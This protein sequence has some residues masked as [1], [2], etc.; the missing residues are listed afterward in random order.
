MTKE[1]AFKI[2]DSL[3]SQLALK[4]EEHKMVQLAL[5]TLKEETK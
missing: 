2:L 4:R 3:V 1:E 5:E